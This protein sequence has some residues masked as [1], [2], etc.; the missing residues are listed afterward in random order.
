MNGPRKPDF[1]KTWRWTIALFSL[2]LVGSYWAL[3]FS[4]STWGSKFRYSYL[5]HGSRPVIALLFIT[6]L[7]SLKKS[8]PI[9]RLG[10]RHLRRMAGFG[11]PCRDPEQ[12]GMVREAIGTGRADSFAETA[13]LGSL[14][15]SR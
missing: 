3:I 1:F 11:P 12:S 13:P 15:R 7:M 8:S 9:R 2:V 10:L 4:S 6:A 14:R 5:F